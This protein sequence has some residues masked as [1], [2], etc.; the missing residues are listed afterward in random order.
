VHYEASKPKTQA[1]YNDPVKTTK[2]PTKTAAKRRLAE[3]YGWVGSLFILGAYALLSFGLISSE[4]AMYHGIFFIGSTGL[5]VVTYIHKAFQ[6]F[7][8][9]VTFSLLALI[10]FIRVVY[11]A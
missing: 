4:S 1:C 10:A 8:V 3:I 7:T 9:N 11:F 5:A 6:S 2:K